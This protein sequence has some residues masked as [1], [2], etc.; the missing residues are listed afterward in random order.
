VADYY[1][2]IIPARIKKLLTLMEP[3]LMLFLIGVVLVVALA[4]YLPLITM[5]GNIR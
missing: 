4:I 3:L 1:D 2:Q 5:M